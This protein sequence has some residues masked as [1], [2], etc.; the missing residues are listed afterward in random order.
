MLSGHDVRNGSTPDAWGI[1]PISVLG[2]EFEYLDFGHPSVN[3]TA[4]GLP[5]QAD[6]E[7]KGPAL[8]AVGYLPL[9][10]PLLD[11]YGKVGFADLHSTVNATNVGHPICAPDS[12][13][14]DIVWIPGVYHMN[15]PDSNVAYGA[16]LKLSPFAVRLEYERVNEIGG[17]SDL[18]SL[19]VTWHAQSLR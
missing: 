7:V 4:L 16:Q 3:G 19:G 18:L 13:C 15:R 1:R 5:L 14:S 6:A 2:A 10:I 11:I 8:F 12:P 17:D 9:P